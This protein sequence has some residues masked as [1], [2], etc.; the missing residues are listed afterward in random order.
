MW[1]KIYYA[2]CH[3]FEPSLTIIM[4][5]GNQYF[6]KNKS[7][8]LHSATCHILIDGWQLMMSTWHYRCI[9]NGVA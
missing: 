8:N 4:D 5:D 1:Q 2:M 6:K 9:Y 7:I 3:N